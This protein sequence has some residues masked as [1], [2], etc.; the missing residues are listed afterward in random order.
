MDR[1]TPAVRAARPRRGRLLVSIAGT[2][3][4]AALGLA[5][6]LGLSATPGP[7]AGHGS[8][9]GVHTDIQSWS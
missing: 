9:H 4:A 2:A 7:A 6:A 8:G 3:L 5:G 1:S